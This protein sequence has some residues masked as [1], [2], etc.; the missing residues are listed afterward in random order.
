MAK[1]EFFKKKEKVEEEKLTWQQ[2]LVRDLKDLLLV[3]AVFMIIY[4]LLFRVVVVVGGSMNN[5]L[6]NGDRLVLQSSFLYR[7]PKQGDIIVASKESFENGNCIIKRVIATEGQLVDIKDGIVYVDNQPLDEQYTKEYNRTF[8]MGAGNM[9]FPQIVPK[10]HLFVLGDNRG[11]SLD[12]RKM[13]IGF[14][15]KREVLGKAFFLMM[16]GRDAVTG[17]KDNGRIG[18]VD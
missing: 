16:P 18:V 11:G 7:N 4:I 2:S 13:Q 5:T 8:L 10:G 9:D 3:L 17:E 1:F 14:V 15:D 12:S 6:I